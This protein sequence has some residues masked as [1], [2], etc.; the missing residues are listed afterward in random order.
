MFPPFVI[1][2][3][4]CSRAG[5]GWVRDLSRSA[6]G[7]DSRCRPQQKDRYPMSRFASLLFAG[8][9][10]SSVAG[11]GAS[12]AAYLEVP[13]AGDIN[14]PQATV[15]V[16]GLSDIFGTIGGAG[17]LADA[18]GFLHTVGGG[19]FFIGSNL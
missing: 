9:L 4:S 16:G 11:S 13:D 1:W 7:W 18:F 5:R 10:A 14:S 6:S 15:G 8:L 2:P 17:D 19:F 3:G 12:A